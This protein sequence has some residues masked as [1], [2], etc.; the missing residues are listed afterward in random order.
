MAFELPITAFRHAP[1]GGISGLADLVRLADDWSGATFQWV[2]AD[3]A[4]G[5]AKITLANA[6]AGS[7]GVSAT[8]AADYPHPTSGADVG[9]TTIRPQ[10]DEATLEGLTSPTT[11]SDDI[12]LYHTLYVTPSGSIKRVLCY[13]AFTIKQG[14]PS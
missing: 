4:G 8:Y 6:A 11:P 14:A 2:F 3:A 7:Q 12:V 1:W 9:A 5:T 13:G 10:I